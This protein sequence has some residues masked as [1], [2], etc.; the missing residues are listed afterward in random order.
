MKVKGQKLICPNTNSNPNC[1]KKKSAVSKQC[2]NCNGF[3]KLGKGYDE[4]Y[5]VE[6][7]FSMRKKRSQTMTNFL[8]DNP[9][10]KTARINRCRNN[11][12]VVQIWENKYGREIAEIKKGEWLQTLNR[13]PKGKDNPNHLPHVK[14]SHS[15]RSI[16]MWEN[17][18]YAEMM[19]ATM[20]GNTFSLGRKHS[21]ETRKKM[22]A[23]FV[24]NFIRKEGFVPNYNKLACKYLDWLMSQ[25]G[26]NIQHAEN[27]G[28]FFIKGLGY[29]VDGYDS[30]NN[31]VYE[32]D[33][34]DH[35]YKGQLK[36]KDLARQKEIEKQL[37]CTFIRIKQNK[38]EHSKISL[39]VR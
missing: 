12:D 36:P 20:T 37:G 16:A 29:W 4:I 30:Q 26:T 15:K 39:G 2:V 1:R 13:F 5:G 21:E 14:E 34:T 24:K 28:E 11:G 23:T 7:S 8:S 32:Y 9:D 3:D 22:R 19:S 10:E 6:L 38:R 31:I 25:T 33:E 17:P 18:E 27:G 35:Y